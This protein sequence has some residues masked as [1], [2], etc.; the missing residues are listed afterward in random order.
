MENKLRNLSSKR[1]SSLFLLE[2]LVP[3]MVVFALNE[4]RI[5]VV[6]V[7]Q[8]IKQ[9]KHVVGTIAYDKSISIIGANVVTK[10]NFCPNSYVYRWQ[11]HNRST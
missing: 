9:A 8:E 11:I 5:Y 1:I 4:K 6:L 7:N 10:G 3:R 2:T